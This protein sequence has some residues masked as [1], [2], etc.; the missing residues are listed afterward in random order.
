VII[1]SGLGGVKAMR[2]IASESQTIM[3]P[4]PGITTRS[5]L[6]CG[7]GTTSR[8]HKKPIISKNSKKK[9]IIASLK[10]VQ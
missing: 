5:V 9:H 7:V 4:E 3:I 10:H 2:L 8:N 1:E 6:I